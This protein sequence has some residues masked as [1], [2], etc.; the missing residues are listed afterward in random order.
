MQKA[1]F[2]ISFLLLIC[3]LANLWGNIKKYRKMLEFMAIIGLAIMAN[4]TKMVKIAA[5]AWPHVFKN[6]AIF[7]VFSKNGQNA[8]Q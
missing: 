6:M 8:D 1:Y 7:Y 4:I 3:I 2:S 5:I